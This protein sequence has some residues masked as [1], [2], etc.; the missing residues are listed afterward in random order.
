MGHFD[1][2]ACD[3][4]WCGISFADICGDRVAPTYERQAA[5]MRDSKMTGGQRRARRGRRSVTWSI[6]LL[7][8][9][10]LPSSDASGEAW[11]H[12]SAPQRALAVRL[13]LVCRFHPYYTP[14][15]T[16]PLP[17]AASRHHTRKRHDTAQL[18]TGASPSAAPYSSAGLSSL[19]MN[20]SLMART[21]LVGEA[22]R[23]PRTHRERV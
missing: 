11:H 23:E 13:P 7:G 22:W 3:V 2:D 9:A 20:D 10:V 6:C 12:L 19:S 14:N 18:Y 1:S 17:T 16:H 4:L 8:L 15:T 5:E 21:S